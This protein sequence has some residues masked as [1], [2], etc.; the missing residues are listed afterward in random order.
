MPLFL[1]FTHNF[2]GPMHSHSSRS[3][4]VFS[5][6]LNELIRHNI[7]RRILSFN[8]A[9]SRFGF[10]SYPNSHIFHRRSPLHSSNNSRKMFHCRYDN[11]NKT[12]PPCLHNIYFRSTNWSYTAS[13][14]K[15]RARD[16][17]QVANNKMLFH[18]SQALLCT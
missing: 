7:C 6:G 11:K 18:P 5:I 4:M 12:K 3:A 13:V 14:L 10:D 17:L 9:F 1:T 15:W 8:Y 16:A 2:K